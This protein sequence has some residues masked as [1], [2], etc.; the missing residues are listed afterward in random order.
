MRSGPCM[1]GD[2][3][4]PS[5]GSA[6]GTYSPPPK[7][8]KADLVAMRALARD[9]ALV[10]LDFLPNVGRCALQ[11]YG[12]LNDSLVTARALGILTDKDK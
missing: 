1:C 12:R 9:L 2:T 3:E 10:V 8:T 7:R 6:Q 11:D 4:C 5:C